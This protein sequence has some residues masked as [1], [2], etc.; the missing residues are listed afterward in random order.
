MSTCLRFLF[1]ISLCFWLGSI[2]FFSLVTAPSVFGALPKPEAGALISVIF[3]KYYI[4]QYILGVISIFSLLLLIFLHRNSEKKFRI[5]RLVLILLMFV[6]TLFSGTYVRNSA[7]EAKSVMT[8]SE[9]AS[10]LYIDSNKRF[11]SS[12]RNSVIINGLVFLFGIVILYNIAKN[13]EI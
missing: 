9:P 5:I 7:I 10:Q 11:K 2:F 13:N 1:L 4:V 6:M 12:H 3:N 8:S